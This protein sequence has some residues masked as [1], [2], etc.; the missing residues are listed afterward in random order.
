MP[1]V[2][3]E[4]LVPGDILDLDTSAG[5]AVSVSASERRRGGYRLD[6]ENYWFLRFTARVDLARLPY[7]TWSTSFDASQTTV[8]Q[9][10]V[11]RGTLYPVRS[12]GYRPVR[13]A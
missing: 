5:L 4:H 12:L 3:V 9:V 2:A 7:G 11:Q 13:R 10:E 6:P 1:D 8:S